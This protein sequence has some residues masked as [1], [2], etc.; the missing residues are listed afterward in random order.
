MKTITSIT[1]LKTGEGIRMSPTFSTIDDNGNIVKSNERFNFVVTDQEVLNQIEV[2][3][4]YAA[5]K[6]PE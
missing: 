4:A 3:N 5:S 2:I 1:V 6:I